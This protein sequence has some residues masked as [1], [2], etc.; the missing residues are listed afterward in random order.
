M[1]RMLLYFCLLAFIPLHAK[2]VGDATTAKISSANLSDNT[3]VFDINN[4]LYWQSN[5]GLSGHNPFSGNSGGIFQKN[6]T[7]AIYV[8]GFVLGV[9]LATDDQPIRVGGRT[10]R[11]GMIPGNLNNDAQSLKIYRIRPDW[12]SLTYFDL[13]EDAAKLF[14]VSPNDVTAEMTE[15]VYN[16]YANDWKNWP[17]A[18]G[19]PFVDVN[20]NGIYDPVLDNDG[21]PDKSKGDYP[22]LADASQI[23]WY[24]MNDSDAGKTFNFL[25]AKPIGFELQVTVWTMQYAPFQNVIFKKFKLK[26]NGQYH[27]NETR[28]GLFGDL[29]IGDYSDDLV[30]CDSTLRLG[31]TYNSAAYDKDFDPFLTPPPAVGFMYLPELSSDSEIQRLHSFGYFSAGGMWSDPPLGIYDGTLSWFNLLRGNEPN[32]N[33]DNPTPMK[34]M[35]GPMAGLPTYFPFDGDPEEDPNGNNSDIDGHGQAQGPGDR[36]MVITLPAFEMDPGD[37]QEFTFAI[38]GEFGV[39]NLNAVTRLKEL[40]TAV[41]QELQSPHNIRVLTKNVRIAENTALAQTHFEIKIDDPASSVSSAWLSIDSKDASTVNIELFDDGTHGDSLAN[42]HVWS[43][44]K[45]LQTKKY[46]ATVN[47]KLKLNS[48][49]ELSFPSIIDHLLLRPVPVLQNLHV[50]WENGKQDRELNHKETARIAYTIVNKDPVF[51]ID[52]ISLSLGNFKKTFDIKIRAGEKDSSDFYFMVTAP[53][54]GTIYN[55]PYF[56]SFDGNSILDTLSIPLQAWQPGSNWGDTLEINNISGSGRSL[57]PIVADS[58]LLNGHQY[59]VT[60]QYQDTVAKTDLLWNLKDLTA[61]ED[62]IVQQPVP[63]EEQPINPVIDGIQWV[64][65]S[66][67]PGIEAIV[68]VADAQ[69]PLTPDEYD[70]KGAPYGGNNVWHSLSAPTGSNLFYLSAGG[71]DGD[72][73]RIERSIDNANNHDFELRFTDQD[74]NIYLWWYD[75]DQWAY[76]PFEFWDVGI[77]YDDPTDDVR[78][79]TGGYSGGATPGEFDFG[80]TD[81]YLGFLATDWIYVRKPLNEDGSYQAFAE[82]VT[83]NAFAFSWWNNSAEV[84]SRLIICDY[85]GAGT[86][87]EAGTVIRFITRKSFSPRDTIFVKA[88]P[89]AIS[90]KNVMPLTYELLQNYP[91]PFNPSTTIEFILAHNEHVRM[92]I[93]NI[94]GQRVRTLID[95]N[96]TQGKHRLIWNGRNDQGQ[97]MP[98]GIYIYRLKSEKFTS[99]KRMLIIR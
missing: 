44:S 84:L 75:S 47:L 12:K 10:Y 30:G 16:Q 67:P 45:S 72:I 61:D 43:I 57:F 40:A 97:I 29:D 63:E 86:L 69:G 56:L 35:S 20:Q 66:P 71:G 91:N 93:F 92:E 96:L 24:V 79:L 28:I 53:D 77:T 76:V 37:E 5:A 27:S 1:R 7:S 23:I 32:T 78:L 94:L 38:L 3:T 6:M 52:V 68:Q 9:N 88:G 18:L 13:I 64:I 62:K 51:D 81:P 82:D 89:T 4:W 95:G 83:S 15:E 39:N 70:T 26:Y 58:S 99:S 65:Y 33:L 14:N 87:P 55:A 17:V 48:E 80:Y 31:Y 22:G 90:D 50:T 73:S 49:D 59:R 21:Y 98:S 54:T 60:F 8:D 25:G 46:P 11:T 2:S 85:S 34:H 19:A 41:H 36:R 74:S 42:D